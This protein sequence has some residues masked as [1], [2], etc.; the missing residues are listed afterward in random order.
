MKKWIWVV[1]TIIIA[2]SVGG[3][4]YARHSQNEK[5]YAQAMQRASLQISNENYPSAET[6]FTNALKR[7]PSDTKASRLLNQTQSFIA[8]NESFDNQQFGTAKDNYQSVANTKKGNEQL[9]D[10]AQMR[11]DTIKTIQGNMK[12]YNKL[13][14]QAL[15]ESGEG[16]YVQFN[17]TLDKL[18]A[19][20]SIKQ[21]YYTSILTKAKKLQKQNNN[22]ISGSTF[23]S[24]SSTASSS[25]DFEQSNSNQNTTNNPNVSSSSSASLT[26]SEKKA[27]NDYKGSNEYTV[28]KK[29]KEVNG[30]PITNNQITKARQEISAAGVDSN[31]MSDQD[32]RNV[33][34]GAHANHQT[35]QQYVKEKY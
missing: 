27:A 34:K 12:T 11:I 24:G 19:D 17:S 20:K 1:I 10:R 26:S 31:A 7:K 23:D 9:K 15:N 16:K 4:A 30:K 29:D 22:A 21:T 18:F 14:D 5:L 25:N 35:I 3:Y 6:S 8:A 28:T 13:Y 33:I 32:I 2:G